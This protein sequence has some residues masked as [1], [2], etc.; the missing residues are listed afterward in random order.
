M[1]PTPAP[2][3]SPAPWSI[4][5]QFD[6]ETTVEIIAADGVM[7]A[8]IAPF[9]EEWTEQEI[10]NVHAMTAAP[11]LLAACREI[12]RV[13]REGMSAAEAQ[14]ALDLVDRAIARAEGRS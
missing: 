7:V 2:A 1:T 9:T 8:E 14:I 5:G 4:S 3:H 12:Q 6:A 10:A 11:Q 13:N